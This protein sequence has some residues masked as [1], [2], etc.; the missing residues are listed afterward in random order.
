MRAMVMVSS[1]S[2]TVQRMSR[3]SQHQRAVMMAA[4]GILTT[5]ER[6]GAERLIPTQVSAAESSQEANDQVTACRQVMSPAPVAVEP[7]I[8]AAHSSWEEDVPPESYL[9]RLLEK[10]GRQPKLL[11]STE[12]GYTRPPTEKQVKDYSSKPFITDLVRKGDIEGLEQA[13]RA[14]RGMVRMLI[15]QLLYR[16]QP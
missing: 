14:G 3:Q 2:N 12:A 7:S 1:G 11:S 9:L 13:L 6:L 16:H 8:L 5:C 4:A 15:E 10:R